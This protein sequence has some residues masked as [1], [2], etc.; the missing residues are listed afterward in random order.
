MEKFD[1]S[2]IIPARNEEW[3]NLTLKDVLEK[4]RGKTEVIV[5]LDGEWPREPLPE[6]SRITVIYHNKSVGQRA[7]VNE[8]ARVSKAKYIMKLDAHCRLDE[9]FDVKL[10]ADCEPNW[11]VVPTLYNLHAFDWICTKCKWRKYQGPTPQECPECK[12]PVKRD[13]IW[14]PRWRRKSDYMR[15]DS[16]LHFQYW[17]DF[18][19]RPEAQEDIVDV[20]GNLGA[21]YF[22]H[23]D[24]FWYLEGLDENH[25][26]W[27]QMGTEISCKTWLAGGRQVVN[28]KTWY[29]HLF[30]TQGGD[31]SFPYPQSGKQIEHARKYSQDL[32]KNNK[33]PKAKHDLN[34]LIK[35]F[36]PVPGWEGVK[37][38]NKPTKGIIYY[39]D[40][41]LKLS[42]AHACKKNIK[43]MGLP[44]TSTSLKPMKDMGKNI[45]VKLERGYEAYFTQILTALK[46]SDADI[47]YF[48]EHDWLYHP[49]HFEFTPKDKHTVYYNWNWWRVR[50]SDG[51]CVHY[52]TQLV[53]GICAYREILIPWYEKALEALKNGI[54]AH[55]IGFEP[56]TSKRVETLPNYTVEKFTSEYPL[57]DLRHTSNLTSS[58]WSQ[59][60]FRSSKNCENWIE[61]K[62]V[63]GWGYMPKV[64]KDLR[65]I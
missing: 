2:V 22:M 43:S 14:T 63:P 58:K 16:D 17:S 54:P 5:I 52:D 13:I 49:S 64:L 57:L 27:G 59:D 61:T 65:I 34:W 29:S 45:V 3:L 30:R 51:H 37:L 15:F 24:W 6:D 23:R 33:W 32:W 48:C 10:M 39:T 7:A 28:K 25:G 35:K 42:I 9:G 4:S 12:S 41:Q 56:G 26:S 55:H 60:A 20:M 38:S 44:I 8:G 21:C 50:V 31:F 1:L 19:K 46:N 36:S 11:T 18:K 40:N 53:P 62:D 47:V